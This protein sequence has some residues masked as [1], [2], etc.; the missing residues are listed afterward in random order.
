MSN[1]RPPPTGGR[2]PRLPTG[3]GRLQTGSFR[4]GTGMRPGSRGVGGIGGGALNS[5]VVI[6][7]R[8]VTGQGLGGMGTGVKGPQRQVQDKSYYL[9]LLRSKIGEL[10]NEVMK[11]TRE[12]DSLQ[13]E[14]ATY[15]TYEK[16]AEVLASEVEDLRGEL[17]DYNTLI[18][19]LNTETEIEA[20]I[21]DYSALCHQNEI[22]SRTIDSL[23]AEKHQH[24]IKANQLETEIEQEKQLTETL[25]ESMDEE[26]R[27]KYHQLKLENAQIKE[28]AEQKEKELESLTEKAKMLKEEV[29]TSDLK[30][31]AFQ[32]HQQL[33]EV[34]AK[35]DEWK[36]KE[37]ETPEQERERLL[38]QV[39]RDNQEIASLE[40]RSDELRDELDKH[41]ES[42]RQTEANLD[43]AQGEKAA[44]IKELKAK[45]DERQSYI[46][47]FEDLKKAEMEKLENLQEMIVGVLEHI[48]EAIVESENLPSVSQYQE[49][50]EDLLYKQEEVKKA[51]KTANTL[52]SQNAQ[53]QKDLHNINE[54]EDKIKKELETLKENISTME[55][56]VEVFSDLEKLRNDQ[57]M[58]EKGLIVEREK[59]AQRK[60][61]VKKNTEEVQAVYE[62]EK[63]ILAKDETYTQLGNLERKLQ[64]IEQNN[65]VMKEFIATRQMEGNYKQVAERVQQLQKDYN[66]LLIQAIQP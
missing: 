57:E 44:K 60:I 46:D 23:F 16:R 5:Q 20:I 15:M 25:I 50:Q 34:T 14:S 30:Q 56:E 37:K 65:F 64:H 48:S 19:K 51:S 21:E 41:Q 22:E 28:D 55:Q 47:S 58:I 8:P 17:G 4:I 54:M 9:G 40:R 39:K 31:R 35:R 42:L 43:E 38:K 66:E 63:A 52:E 27:S 3:S 53:L 45:E 13:Q 10:N 1:Y 11:L 61:A 32:L 36:Q 18:D 12:L 6:S 59:L 49:L 7:D 26:V 33:A 29:A 2:P 62:N 24:E